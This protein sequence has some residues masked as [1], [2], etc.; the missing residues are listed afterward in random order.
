VTDEVGIS[1]A[2]CSR[3][4][5]AVITTSGPTRV[6]EQVDTVLPCTETIM[7]TLRATFRRMS[8]AGMRATFSQLG[9]GGFL[10]QNQVGSYIASVYGVSIRKGSLLE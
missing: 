6:P 5:A 2:G 1:S 10:M 8:P 7:H 3:Q 9:V 4:C